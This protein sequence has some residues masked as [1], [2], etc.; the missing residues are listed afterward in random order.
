M[1]SLISDF[2]VTV[3][4]TAKLYGLPIVLSTVNVKTGVNQPTIHQL[5]KVLAGFVFA[6]S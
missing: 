2:L 1:V 4:R 5:A 6:I 3:A